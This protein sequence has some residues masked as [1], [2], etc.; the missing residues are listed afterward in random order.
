M[1]D[2]LLGGYGIKDIHQVPQAEKKID[3]IV[4]SLNKVYEISGL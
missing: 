1:T 3:A 4:N 2:L